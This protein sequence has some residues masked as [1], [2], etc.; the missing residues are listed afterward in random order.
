MTNLLV[1]NLMIWGPMGLHGGLM[2]P[3]GA[4]SSVGT[5]MQVDAGELG[6]FIASWLRDP[7]A[8]NSHSEGE[9]PRFRCI[10]LRGIRF[11]G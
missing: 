4:A 10:L 6:F 9:G 11:W 5:L 3:H 2:G 8:I 1:N 7:I